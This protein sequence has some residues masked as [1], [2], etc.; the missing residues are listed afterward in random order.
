M[1]EMISQE[2]HP[3]GTQSSSKTNS[4]VIEH[5]STGAGPVLKCF[6]LAQV[7]EKSCKEKALGKRPGIGTREQLEGISIPE[8]WA[9]A[10]GRSLQQSDRP[11]W[12]PKM[13][14]RAVRRKECA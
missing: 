6:P 8:F 7:P 4:E 14:S 3:R 2:I 11:A 9:I 13:R 1:D 10:P 12:R 5:L